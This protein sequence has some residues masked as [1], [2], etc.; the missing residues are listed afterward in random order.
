MTEA[1]AKQQWCPHARIDG[2]QRGDA[3]YNRDSDDMPV[4]HCIGSACMAWRWL[5]LTEQDRARIR[6]ATG[7]E[8]LEKTHGYCGLAGAP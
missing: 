7:L 1:E 3:A 2:E 8:I 6:A 4:G 5:P